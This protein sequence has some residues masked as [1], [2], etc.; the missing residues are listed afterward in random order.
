MV[1]TSVVHQIISSEK[2]CD[3]ATRVV[4]KQMTRDKA[5]SYTT[6]PTQQDKYIV[7]NY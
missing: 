1:L 6:H 4:L 5:S 7:V 3:C 2:M